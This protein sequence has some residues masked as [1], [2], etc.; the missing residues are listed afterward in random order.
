M[1]KKSK[2]KRNRTTATDEPVEEKTVYVLDFDGDMKASEVDGFRE[3]I[4]AVLTIAKAHDEVVLKLESPGGMVH[5]YGS[6]S[7]SISAI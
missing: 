3:E 6:S 7:L 2:L 4:T 5:A 1:P